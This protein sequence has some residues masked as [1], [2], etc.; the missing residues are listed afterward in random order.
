MGFVC[1]DLVSACLAGVFVLCSSLRLYLEISGLLAQNYPSD[2]TYF[3]NSLTQTVMNGSAGCCLFR[4]PHPGM[5]AG[6]VCSDVPKTKGVGFGLVLFC[7]FFFFFLYGAIYYY[8]ECIPNR[9]FI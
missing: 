6:I 3:G 2:P 4:N 5:I 9:I 8:K 1:S 7:L